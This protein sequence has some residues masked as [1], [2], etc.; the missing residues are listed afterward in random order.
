MSNKKLNVFTDYS[1]KILI[2]GLGFL[3]TV[4]SL[5]FQSRA[6]YIR[7]AINN[8]FSD[9]TMFVIS[10][11]CAFNIYEYVHA[12]EGRGKAFSFL[13]ILEVAG[14]MLMSCG[15]F[16][17]VMIPSSG[18]GFIEI[19]VVLVYLLG[20]SL[21]QGIK[22][23]K[24]RFTGKNPWGIYIFG[25]LLLIIKV[26][27]FYLLDEN[28]YLQFAEG[29]TLLRSLIFA[30]TLFGALGI[31]RLLSGI[32]SASLG[33]VPEKKRRSKADIKNVVVKV[34]KS[35][36]Q[37]I[38]KLVSFVLV[39]FSGWVGII[40]LV[41]GGLVV[42][43]IGIFAFN[44]FFDSVMHFVEPLL[45]KFLTTGEYTVNPG[46][47]YTFGQILALLIYTF[48][49][50]Y[51]T[52]TSAT[53]IE[54]CC[55]GTLENYVLNEPEFKNISRNDLREKILLEFNDEKNEIKKISLASDRSE[56]EKI[57]RDCISGDA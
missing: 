28:V 11:M 26:F 43:G 53:N 23:K 9:L 3:C 49:V 36:V 41:V 37:G 55:I 13:D 31:L 30:I 5:V 17:V 56:L 52:K 44:K 57:A 34:W 18:F 20:I 25:C 29:N 50:F 47:V 39:C 27:L 6:G 8:V 32:G 42:L 16:N 19:I 14:Y 21:A 54:K 33:I 4:S 46:P 7:L 22:T 12:C 40:I 10:T 51:I 35:L 48:F 1:K 38:K 24:I 15:F 2:L 45:Q